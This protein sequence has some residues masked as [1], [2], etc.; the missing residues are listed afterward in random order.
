LQ[1]DR[2]PTFSIAVEWENARFAELERARRMLRELRRQLLE[3]PSP[4]SKPEI[5]FLFDR[6][7]IDGR[8]VQ[9]TVESELR[10]RALPAQIRIVPTDGLRYYQQKNHGAS[11]TSGEIMIFLDCDVMPEPGWLAAMLA[12][13][14]EPSVGAVAGQTYIEYTG[15]YSKAFALFWFF[16]LRDASNELIPA[17]FFHANNVA[18]R[19]EVISRHPFPDLACYRGQC[20]IL[21]DTLR[22]QGIGLYAK[23]SARVAHPCPL[24]WWYFL[25]RAL[26]NGRDGMIVSQLRERRNRPRWRLVY[27][28]YRS[29]LLRTWGR[30]RRERRTVGL[31]PAGMVLALAIA[32]AYHTLA[33]VGEIVSRIR[34][35]LISRLFPI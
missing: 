6:H 23:Q 8:M 20:T 4:P 3:V 27:W 16:G 19:R 32:V 29:A 22:A 14:R 31:G 17:T 12:A 7:S 15:V 26:N 24:G 2:T 30:L 34:P 18:F 1:P 28:K 10:P 33:A 5:V 11:I 9:E 13:F 25:A 35:N 21:G